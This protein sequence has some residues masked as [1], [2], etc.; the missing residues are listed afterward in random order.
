MAVLSL[1]RPRLILPNLHLSPIAGIRRALAEYDVPVCIQS[2][3]AAAAAAPAAAAA[4]AAAPCVAILVLLL[5][6]D[7]VRHRIPTTR[8]CSLYNTNKTSTYCHFFFNYE[9]NYFFTP[10]GST[11]ASVAPRLN[12]ILA[13]MV[14]TGMHGAAD[15][16]HPAAA[17]P[18]LY[19]V[20]FSLV[21]A[22]AIYESY[23]LSVVLQ[24]VRVT[25]FMPTC[26]KY[27][28]SVYVYI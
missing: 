25:F 17:K 20:G 15:R 26:T 5:L 12:Y 10:L 1:L 3:A 11:L 2:A 14:I 27:M 28:Y 23:F 4:A 24:E 8:V 13:I 22:A 16:R 19:L 18:P 7:G 9:R 6:A 21:L